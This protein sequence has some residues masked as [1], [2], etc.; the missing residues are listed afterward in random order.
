MACACPLLSVYS[1]KGEACGKIANFPAEFQAPIP[2]DIMNFIHTNLHKINRQFYAVSELAGHQASVRV[3][4]ELWLEFLEF[5]V[6]A[7][8]S[9]PGHFWKCVSWAMHA[10]TSQDLVS[11]SEHNTEAVCHLLCLA[12]LAHQHWSY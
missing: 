12:A 8:P 1:K 9:W 10:C 3:L 7:T 2:P 11:Q 5:E 4:V 6:V